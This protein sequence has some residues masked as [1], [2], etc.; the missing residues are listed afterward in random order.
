MRQD[1]ASSWKTEFWG[2]EFPDVLDEKMKALIRQNHRLSEDH[3]L[4]LTYVI[5][6]S[7]L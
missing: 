5:M 2:E 6:K 3:C 1:D 4:L 7:V